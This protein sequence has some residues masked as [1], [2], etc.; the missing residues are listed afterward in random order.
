ML[1]VV[2]R[3]SGFPDQ[4]GSYNKKTGENSGP[5]HG[6]N[7]QE[8][9]VPLIGRNVGKVWNQPLYDIEGRGHHDEEVEQET[10]GHDRDNDGQG[11]FEK[12]GAPVPENIVYQADIKYREEDRGDAANDE[13]L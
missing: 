9:A 12:L 10:R 4:C 11:A 3:P 13:G 2:D 1:E 7:H 5:D 6:S 8:R